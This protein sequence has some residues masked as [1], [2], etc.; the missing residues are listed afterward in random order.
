MTAYE[1]IARKRDGLDLSSEEIEFFINGYTNGDIPDYQMSALLMAIY[2]Q[3]MNETESKSLT[4]TF[5]HSGQIIN[6]DHIS[7]IKVDKHSTGGVGDKTSIILAPIVAAAGVP[8]PMISGRSL[9]HSGGTLDKLESIPGF[10]VDY[11][12]EQF[13]H[14]LEKIGVCLIGQTDELAPA[15]K[16]IYALR[17]VTATV[18]SV[19]LIGASIMSKK[20]AEGI[21][22]LV[23]DVKTGIGAFMTEY[24]QSVQLAKTLIR[25]GEDAGITTIAYITD[26]NSPLG[27]TVGNWLEIVE[28]IECLK[29]D[30][31][32][33]LMD[34]TH[35]LA[36]AMIYLGGKADSIDTGIGISKDLIQ[37]GA[38]WSKLIEIVEE[39]EGDPE[40]IE[41]PH[42]YTKS[43]YQADYMAP[44]NGWIEIIDAYEVGM[45]ALQ[46]GAGRQKS[47]DKIDYKSGIR[48]YHKVGEKIE[49][50]SPILTVYTDKKEMVDNV[51][52]RLNPAIKI[53]SEPTAPSKLILDCI[54]KNDLEQS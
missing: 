17:D 14:K 34:I 24:E 37:S 9:G 35:Q 8:V 36:G 15:D 20:I 3:G 50:G 40:T 23:L 29:G 46:L 13:K 47:E 12:I 28:C 53:S 32:A 51:L 26:M 38:A 19:P 54:D 21:N 27:N 30:G 44:K 22:A 5:I 16:K 2:F 6:L 41:N 18:Q 33:D 25:I 4:H 7:S 42:R 52:E 48:F 39:Q 31:P 43:K 45:V 49:R 11:N 1:I 10:R